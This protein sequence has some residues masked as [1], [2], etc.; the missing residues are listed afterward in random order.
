MKQITSNIYCHLS[1]EDH[2]KHSINDIRA[3]QALEVSTYSDL[4][5]HIAYIS[6]HNPE[7]ALFFRAQ[8]RDHMN[9]QN[10]STIYPSI[11]RSH[12]ESRPSS[13]RIE[14]RF[15]VL[16]EAE[17]QLLYECTEKR[18]LGLSKLN[19]FREMRWA[20]LQHY[21]VCMTPLLDVTHSLRVACSFALHNHVNNPYVFVL[22]LPHPY[23]SI[24]YFV[25]DELLIVRLLSICPPRALRPYFQEGFSIGSFPSGEKSRNDKYD[26]ARRL[27]AKFRLNRSTFSDENFEPI[28]E[29]SLFP[30]GDSIKIKCDQIRMEL[31]N[32]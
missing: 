21:E 24:S 31:D 15:S 28:T 26:F 32:A 7:Y 22:A 1:R 27:I 6:Y 13:K 29:S 30:S 5:K 2:D 25:E 23:G 16:I 17:E 11:Y 20:I 10:Y 19:K 18:L 14:K 3:S 12:Q 8:G 4:V 9:S